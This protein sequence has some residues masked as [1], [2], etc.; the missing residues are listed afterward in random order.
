MQSASTSPMLKDL[1]AKH[2]SETINHVKRLENAFHILG[3]PA[4][5]ITCEAMEGIT[6]EGDGI[7]AETKEGTS[8]RNVGLILAAQK[9]EHYEIAT[10]GVLSQIAH[11]L[12]LHDIAGLMEAT[13]DE[14][15]GADKLLSLAASSVIYRQRLRRN[16]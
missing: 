9:V 15:K 2:L 11:L 5:G 8:T 16:N 3:I 14:E 6:K 10:Y 4:E 12:G 13:M 7:I 1:F